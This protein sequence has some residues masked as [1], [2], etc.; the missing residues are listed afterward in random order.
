MED[1]Y[2]PNCFDKLDR[3]EGCG[4]IGYFCPTCKGLISRSKMLTFE[5][6][7]EETAKNDK[8]ETSEK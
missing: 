1:F 8:N 5:Q 4:S 7:K 2:C 3:Y 6:M